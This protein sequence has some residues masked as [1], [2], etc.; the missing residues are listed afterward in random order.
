MNHGFNVLV[1]DLSRLFDAEIKVELSEILAADLIEKPASF[2]EQTRLAQNIIVVFH[3]SSGGAIALLIPLGVAK[4][5]AVIGLPGLP[6]RSAAPRADVG[7]EGESLEHIDRLLKI[8]LPLI[9]LL[10]EKTETLER[11][12]NYSEGHIIEFDKGAEEMLELL[13]VDKVVARGEAVKIGE[14]FGIRIRNVGSARETL[15]K[16]PLKNS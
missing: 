16:L 7:G 8:E 2:A 14:N 4:E 3:V 1:T 15:Q 6:K 11:V 12:L 13:V 5:L 10:A 9:V